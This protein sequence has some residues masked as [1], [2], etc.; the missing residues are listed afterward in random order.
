MYNKNL[1]K[2]IPMLNTIISEKIKK[3][4]EASSDNEKKELC[5]VTKEF[6]GYLA[7][8][9]PSIV[10]AGLCQTV[11][12]YEDK[13]KCIN[14]IIWEALKKMNWNNNKDNIKELVNDENNLAVKDHVMDVIS[15]A[16]LV[17]RTFDLEG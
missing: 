1:E 2:L 9:G 3:Y 17:I 14:E 15:A 10:M 12:F 11:Y 8:Y 7:S 4:Q 16:K 5:K 6:K 13:D